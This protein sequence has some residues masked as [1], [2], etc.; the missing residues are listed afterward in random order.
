MGPSLLL[1]RR[2]PIACPSEN[3]PGFSTSSNAPVVTPEPT[4]RP[5]STNAA[6]FTN[7]S[8]SRTVTVIV[9]T[10]H[11][12]S[13]TTTTATISTIFSLPPSSSP[14]SS[15]P[16]SSSSSSTKQINP[17]GLIVGL[18]VGFT[19]LAL[20]MALVIFLLWRRRQSQDVGD[21]EPILPMRSLRATAF[22]LPRKQ[23][24]NSLV[25]ASPNT[26]KPTPPAPTSSR[27][28]RESFAEAGLS[29]KAPSPR[30]TNTAA[31]APTVW[32][33]A[34]EAALSRALGNST[35]V[36]GGTSGEPA[37]AGATQQG[38]QPNSRSASPVESIFDVSQR[39]T[40]AEI[41]ASWAIFR[42]GPAA[43]HGLSAPPRSRDGS[44]PGSNSNQGG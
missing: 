39:R 35:E 34:R 42:E 36:R 44:R 20:M 41:D 17:V 32:R 43:F 11:L 7:L 33:H 37:A 16:S 38:A 6:S 26:D 13:P 24:P 23:Q 21:E 14:S 9:P 22:Y 15:S 1:P 10:T 8:T 3:R 28:W 29:D 19:V 31:P 4:A 25:L 2:L 18:T 30:A 27:P 40:T 12:P 5:F